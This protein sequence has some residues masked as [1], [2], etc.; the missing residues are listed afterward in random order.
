M[1]TAELGEKPPEGVFQLLTA[2]DDV[3]SAYGGYVAVCGAVMSVSGLPPTCYFEVVTDRNPRSCPECVREAF[4][5]S[6]EA[7]DR[8]L[9][10]R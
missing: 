10:T 9:A 3:A 5:W 4:R 6:A 1:S 7:D 2:D 8:H